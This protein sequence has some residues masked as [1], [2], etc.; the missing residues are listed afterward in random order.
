MVRTLPSMRKRVGALTEH[1]IRHLR[2]FRQV[3]DAGGVTAAVDRFGLELTAVSRSLRALEDRLDGVLCLRGPKGFSLTDYGRQVYR[4]AASIEDAVEDAR[5]AI[6]VAHQGFEGEVRLGVADNCLTNAE[7][8]ISD[9]IELFLEIAPSVRIALSILPTDQLLGAIRQREV[10]I[11]IVPTDAS[12]RGLVSTRLFVERASLYCC[13]RPNETPPHLDR[14][15]ARGYGMVVRRFTRDGPT[16]LSREIPAAWQVEASGIEAVATMI[17][18]GRCVGFLPDHYVTGTRM[19]RP[20]M[21]V[22]GAEHLSSDTE[23]SVVTDRDRSVSRAVAALKGL[24]VDV[25]QS[26]PETG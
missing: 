14:L 4:A 15:T 26:V 25:A 11:G 2:V 19:R 24:L 13:P 18:T 3:T 16:R 20:F 10:H 8:K 21:R 6:G 9:A 1:D 12:D 23:F 5:S 17:N 22:P 7:A